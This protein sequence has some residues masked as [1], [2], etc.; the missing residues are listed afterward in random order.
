[1]KNCMTIDVDEEAAATLDTE[2]VVEDVEEDGELDDADVDEGV[3]DRLEKDNEEASS[4]SR[5]V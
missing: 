3:E 2:R 4:S 5:T 1:M